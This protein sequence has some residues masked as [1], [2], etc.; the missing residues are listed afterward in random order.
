MLLQQPFR[1]VPF[2]LFLLFTVVLQS[3]LL[4]IQIGNPQQTIVA[5]ANVTR[6]R[7][8]RTH[9][10]RRVRTVRS[11][12]R[13]S[14]M[15]DC[16][17]LH[18]S[19]Q[20]CFHQRLR[21]RRRAVWHWQGIARWWSRRT[22]MR[23]HSSSPFIFWMALSFRRIHCSNPKNHILNGAPLLTDNRRV[24]ICFYLFGFD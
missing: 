19:H 16:D 7:I 18:F 8:H 17:L 6:D 14:G 9:G 3:R 10:T 24:F 1:G 20:E 23:R 15:P 21:T 11:Q 22:T 4:G 13:S 12:Q 2:Y 5:L